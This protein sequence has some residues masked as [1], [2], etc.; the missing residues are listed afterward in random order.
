M[1]IRTRLTL[2]F[3]LI[4]ATIFLLALVLIYAQ[5]KISNENEYMRQL[6]S[7]ARMTADMVLRH[8][9]DLKILPEN[10]SENTF[11]LP[12][13]E[14]TTIFNE[15][16]ERVFSLNPND[17]ATLKFSKKDLEK[18][19]EFKYSGDGNQIFGFST[20]SISGKKYYVVSEGKY[21]DA[22]LKKLLN[23]LIISFLLVNLVVVSGGWFFAGEAIRPVA[24]IVDEV[25]KI[26]TTDLSRRLKSDN[27]HDELSHLVDTFNRLLDRIEQAFQMQRSFISNVSHEL[28]NP[29]AAM[30]AQLQFVRQKDRPAVE[31]RSVLDSLHDDVRAITETAEKLL[32]L[33]KVNSEPAN[34]HFS[35]IRL[36]EVM[37]QAR[38]SL[39]KMH[40]NYSVVFDF[41]KMP[42]EEENLQ[43]LGN[44]LLLRS[45]LMN[46]FDNGCKFS[47]DKKVAVRILFQDNGNHQVEIQDKGP[48][49]PADEIGRIFEPFFRSPQ[50]A[51]VKGS[52][53]GLSLVE[54]IF[55]LHKVQMEVNSGEKQG[56]TF[57]LIF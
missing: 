28:K 35:K 55:K 47:P 5:F 56:T 27:Q 57:R 50:H 31:Y 20:K 44:E 42:T 3:F 19:N 12:A 18:G 36:D 54:S 8:E 52:G 25:D 40:P 51:H 43:F 30:D 7:K 11:N 33:A 21:D 38:D 14:N 22:N 37:L 15:K 17:N 29:L 32:Q 45:A 53:I 39:L 4:A 26:N 16:F 10:R 13:F 46:L 49:I 6:E 9:E 41:V 2:Q 23:I 34:I 24:K 48:G 1:Q